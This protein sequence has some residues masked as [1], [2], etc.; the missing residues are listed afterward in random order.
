MLKPQSS[1]HPFYNSRHSCQSYFRTYPLPFPVTV[2]MVCLIK[3][4]SYSTQFRSL[5]SLFLLI[6]Q[7]RSITSLST[8]NS[9]STL[10]YSTVSQDLNVSSFKQFLFT[11]PLTYRPFFTI[12]LFLIICVLLYPVTQDRISRLNIYRTMTDTINSFPNSP[13]RSFQTHY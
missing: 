8:L 6:K 12:L 11:K 3:P 10:F 2:S 9:T 1:P 7:T 13:L 5:F 4:I